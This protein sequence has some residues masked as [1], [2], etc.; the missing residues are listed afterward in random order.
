MFYSL[1][2]FKG[3]VHLEAAAHLAL[4]NPP[5]SLGRL[6]SIQPRLPVPHVIF[7][8]W[9]SSPLP[10]AWYSG[11]GMHA[12]SQI[13]QLQ[14][15][16]RTTA[17]GNRR[18]KRERGR[19]RRK[20]ERAGQ[21]LVNI[22]LGP[23]PQ[24]DDERKRGIGENK[25]KGNRKRFFIYFFFMSVGPLLVIFF[26]FQTSLSEEFKKHWSSRNMFPF[27]LKSTIQYIF[28]A[29]VLSKGFRCIVQ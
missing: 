8:L 28:R 25:G 29:Y 21:W 26:S 9:H 6:W 3:R 14:S 11:V 13:H 1:W 18:M 15:E 23:K 16:C 10:T 19:E 2:L 4:S 22:L 24:A 17:Q 12:P 5:S 7:F 20:G 27:K